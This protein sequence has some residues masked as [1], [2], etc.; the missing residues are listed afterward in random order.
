[1]HIVLINLQLLQLLHASQE[2]VT[3]VGLRA[4]RLVGCA[5]ALLLLPGSEPLFIVVELSQE[6]REVPLLQVTSLIS[7]IQDVCLRVEVHASDWEED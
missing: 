6:L 7:R 4:G 2:G 5:V 3:L 1:M